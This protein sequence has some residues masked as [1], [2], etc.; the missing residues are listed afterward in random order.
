MSRL[1][2]DANV[3]VVG[4]RIVGKDLAREIVRVWFSTP[5][6]GG[7]HMRRLDK[8]REIEKRMRGTGDGPG[9]TANY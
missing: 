8:I 1:H 2:N 4:G 5:F 3:L 9:T 6:E 7:R